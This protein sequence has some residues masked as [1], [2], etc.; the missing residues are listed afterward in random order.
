MQGRAHA[1]DMAS[2]PATMKAVVTQAD[3]T[4]ALLDVPVPEIDEDEILVKTTA[5][6]QN[7]TD[8][9]RT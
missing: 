5:V 9:K 7:P 2:L 1:I 4:I 8:W 3:K 6:A